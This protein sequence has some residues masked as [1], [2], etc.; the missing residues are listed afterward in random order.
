VYSGRLYGGGAAST[1]VSAYIHIQHNF[2]ITIN[3]FHYGRSQ[4]FLGGGAVVHI[5]EVF[6][7][8]SFASIFSGENRIMHISRLLAYVESINFQAAKRQTT[9]YAVFGS[10]G[11][12]IPKNRQNAITFHTSKGC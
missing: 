12:D 8:I 6:S 11:R 4:D 10:T 2:L 9:I 3:H 1:A 7:L 5:Q